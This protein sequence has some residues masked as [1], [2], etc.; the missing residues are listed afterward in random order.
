MERFDAVLAGVLDEWDDEG[1]LVVVTSDH[2]NLEDLGTRRHTLNS[3]PTLVVGRRAPE[4]AEGYSRL[5][6]YVQA[7]DRIL[8]DNRTLDPRESS[9]S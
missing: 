7:C 5:T 1:G 3:V 4:F 2:G 8:F 9:S 6:D